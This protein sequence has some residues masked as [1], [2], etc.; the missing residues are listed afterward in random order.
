MIKPF[1]H[2]LF[3]PGSSIGI[4]LEFMAKGKFKAML[5]V[6]KKLGGQLR[7]VHV[8][9]FDTYQQL[10][11]YLK[12]HTYTPLYL[13]LR[14]EGIIQ[15]VF[16]GEKKMMTSKGL[17]RSIQHLDGVQLRAL[18]REEFVASVI[19][20]FKAEKLFVLGVHPG[21]NL[22]P[23]KSLIKNARISIDSEFVLTIQNSR[24]TLRQ[25]NASDLA[26]FQEE[27]HTQQ[28]KLSMA[29]TC[30]FACALSFVQNENSNLQGLDMI[31][32]NLNSYTYRRRYHQVLKLSVVFI[33]SLL[34]VNYAVFDYYFSGNTV[35]DQRI[36]LSR[37]ELLKVEQKKNELQT[38]KQF[39]AVNG[40]G[41][42]SEMALYADQLALLLPV[43]TYFESLNLCPMQKSK[44]D[45]QVRFDK[46]QIHIRARTSHTENINRY[47]EQ[48]E[49]LH[50]VDRVS[51]E[52]VSP[53]N[54]IEQ[55]QFSL[56]LKL[57][58]S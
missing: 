40:L 9:E 31:D 33:L 37:S 22:S 5:C 42:P 21:L 39:V 57:I 47:I 55:L 56:I 19:D 7:Q 32:E 13:N 17:H 53:K 6:L 11:H 58:S 25:R 14:G 28:G 35:L 2:K 52:S 18:V 12:D 8:Q 27:I 10:F 49:K 44:R 34:L 51:I 15:Q 41:V 38:K 24:A 48:I 36:A 30:S 46:T 3:K 29:R 43:D 45:K 26:E 1:L 50:W 16:E 23:V 4:D 20:K 54:K